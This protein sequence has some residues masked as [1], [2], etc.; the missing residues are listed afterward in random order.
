MY[1]DELASR[2][3]SLVPADRLPP[4]SSDELFRLYAILL[5]AKGESTSL[6]D[7]HDAWAAWK[8][9]T[10]PSHESLV[11]YHDL[12]AEVREQD[13]VFC[14]AIHA[15]ASSNAVKGSESSG[16]ASVLFPVGRPAAGEAAS[17]AFEL[18]K[19]MVASS[20]ALVSRRQ[21]V[22]TFFLT[23]NGALLTAS[24]LI[25][26]SSGSR[27]L[28]A[29]GVAV[30]TVAGVLLCGAWR[31]LIVSF[32][33]LN[34]GKF[35]VINEMEKELPAA[36]YAAE[37]EALGRGKDPKIYR[38]FTS[39]E[40]WVPTALLILHAAAFLVA[41]LVATGCLNLFVR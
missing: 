15:A 1:L 24:G 13:R 3:R 29:I 21:G 28:G 35:K 2:I 39:R 10:D 37:W 25:V 6:E 40:I 12:P 27:T 17:R 34:T 20:E 36:I 32:G 14:E 4:E 31:S 38:S 41:T 5:R 9:K 7:V 30:L 11:P 8:A 19:L 22:N 33:Q 26:Q 16:F 18:Y 23:M